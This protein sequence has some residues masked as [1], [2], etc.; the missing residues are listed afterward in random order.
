MAASHPR[1]DAAAGDDP[2]AVVTT[3]GNLEDAR[4]IGLALVERR[5]S[6]CVQLTPIESI[7][8]WDGAIQQEPEVRLLLKTTEA[9]RPELEQ[10]L[11]AL[12]PYALPALYTVRLA[13]AH[14]PYADWITANAGAG[15]G[16][17]DGPAATIEG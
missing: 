9:R 12:H 5:L 14:A 3:V 4:R 16:G 11:L 8:R 13:H 7:Y 6:A 10:A 1:V 2:V 15:S 17:E